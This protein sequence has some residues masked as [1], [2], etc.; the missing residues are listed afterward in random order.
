MRWPVAPLKRIALIFAG[1][2]RPDSLNEGAI[3]LIGA[4]GPIGGVE[5]SNLYVLAIVVGRVGSAGAVN[6]IKPPAWISDNA[7]VA[8]PRDSLSDVRY[9]FYVMTALDMP[10]D[11][12]QT[13]QPLIT[14]SAVRERIVPNPSVDQ[15]RAIADYLDA[16][17]T[18]IDALI[19]K[20]QRMVELLEERQ[21]G[22]V[23][24]SVLGLD[25]SSS[26]KS[27]SGF[28]VGIPS[29]WLETTI[30][31][32]D[33]EVQT[34]PFG[35]QLHA[36]DYIENGWPVVNPSNL[37]DGSIVELATMTISTE[38]RAELSR[39]IL[40]EGDIV[41]GRRG[42]MGR[43]GLVESRHAGWLCGTGSLRLRLS[44]RSPLIS[45]YLKLLLETTALRSYFELTSVGSTMD[46]LNSDIV[47]GMPC[48]I[49]PQAEQRRVIEV[50][51]QYRMDAA[52]LSSRLV[53]QIALLQEH[54]QALITAAV[55]GQLDIPGLAA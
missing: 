53:R 55:T 18:R 5:R 15:Q 9:L 44:S 23:D 45:A 2:G 32:L 52:A 29:D 10:S 40:R 35:S 36:E 19:A 39:H 12:A 42:E 34:G 16:E 46:N 28:F 24:S 14:Q 4:N 25:A 27:M 37:K 8:L 49:P 50:V 38:K 7:L 22:V 54:R 11:A 47:L 43:A 31:H 48:L 6:L 13:A 3:P 51:E 30:R 33:C 20:K 17:T 41:F 1:E 21:T 26:R